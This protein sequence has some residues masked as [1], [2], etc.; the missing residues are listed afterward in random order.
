M[1]FGQEI[2]VVDRFGPTAFVSF[3]HCQFFWKYHDALVCWCV[4]SGRVWLSRAPR[5]LSSDQGWSASLKASE[6][7]EV[8]D[9]LY[10]WDGL[11]LGGG[12]N[13][14]RDHFL[15][16]RLR[17]VQTDRIRN[18]FGLLRNREC[19]TSFHDGVLRLVATSWVERGE[20]TETIT[21]CQNL[22]LPLHT[23]YALQMTLA[24]CS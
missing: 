2:T 22:D 24:Q 17:F 9:S 4:S 10:M 16:F 6:A 8:V 19:W 18:C 23:K 21:Y 11:D 12:R 20:D 1:C 14:D 5:D 3:L 13:D 7:R 15:D